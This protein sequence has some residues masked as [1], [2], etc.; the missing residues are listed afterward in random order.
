LKRFS[1]K[2][3]ISAVT[4]L[5]SEKKPT[6]PSKLAVDEHAEIDAYEDSTEAQDMLA[7]EHDSFQPEQVNVELLSQTRIRP[8]S[9]E[10]AMGHLLEIRMAVQTLCALEQ[11]QA[12][13]KLLE[14]HIDAVPNTCA[15]AYMECMDLC[16]KLGLRD[17]FE[18]MRKRYRL[19][20]NRLAP[21][22]MEPNTAVQNLESY[23]RPMGELCA[24]WAMQERPKALMATW[25]LGTLHSRRLF[26]LPAYH[27]LL[28]LYEMLEFYDDQSSEVQDFVPTVSLLDLDYEFAIEVKL[29]AQ[30]EQDV[31]RA[32]PT[33]KTGDFDVDFNLITQPGAL[34]PISTIPKATSTQ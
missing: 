29:D 31:L 28:D 30:S 32:I 18:V 10:D 7:P 16:S 33:V 19:Q 3:Q 13:Q 34:S 17:E 23:E 26:Q 15:W 1:R 4:S 6:Q 8:M 5:N 21:Y 12:A 2:Q 27:D 25:L 11:P 22:W 9:S 20:F 24:A 14:Q